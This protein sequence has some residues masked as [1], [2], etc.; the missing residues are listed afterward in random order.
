MGVELFYSPWLFETSRRT[1]SEIVERSAERASA[2]P[3][4]IGGRA[5]DGTGLFISRGAL[6]HRCWNR[7]TNR[8]VARLRLISTVLAPE[9]LIQAPG[10]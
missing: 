5:K 9:P 7:C 2:T 8:T 10:R 3:V 6:A 4:A 1:L